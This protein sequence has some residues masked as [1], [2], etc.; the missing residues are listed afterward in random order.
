METRPGSFQTVLRF[1]NQVELSV[2]SGDGSYSNE[3]APYE[4][5]VFR[6]GEFTQFPGI[7]GPFDDVRGHLI[8]QDVDLIIKKLVTVTKEDPVQV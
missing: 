4:I 3:T 8:E 2:I 1:G 6:N 5:A 7:T